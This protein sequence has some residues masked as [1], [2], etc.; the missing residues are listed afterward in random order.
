MSSNEVI[1]IPTTSISKD[2]VVFY[3]VNIKMPL[4]STSVLRRYSEFSHLVDQLCYDIGINNK[5]FPYK[6]PLKASIWSMTNKNAVVSER[7]TELALFLNQ[8]LRD[9]DLQNHP[10]VHEFLQLP[11]SFKVTTSMLERKSKDASITELVIPD[12]QGLDSHKWL[13]YSRLFKYH[14]NELRES[15]SSSGNIGM[16]VDIR[17]KINKIIKPNLIQLSHSLTNLLNHHKIDKREYNKRHDIIESL[18]SDLDGL[19][20]ELDALNSKNSNKQTLFSNSRRVLGRANTSDNA[21]ETNDTLPL[22]NQEL[23]QQQIQIHQQQDQD[24]AQLRKLI[25]RQRE[26]GQTI[27]TEVEEQNEL[28]DQ[29]NQDVDRTTDRL[30]EARKRARN[31]L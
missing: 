8:V 1:T 21:E 30:R 18:K 5:D 19:F 14:I 25:Q 23:L 15:Y 16:K 11:T 6:L 3:N 28:L 31:I 7:Q 2:N 20:G 24:V 29:V 22:N 27:N 13:E 9:K 26:I 12:A 10:L 4:R 17:D